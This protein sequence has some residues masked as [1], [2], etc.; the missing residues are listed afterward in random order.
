[1]KINKKF[2]QFLAAMLILIFHIWI[3][4]WGN[5][6][7]DF[8]LKTGYIGVDIFFFLSAYSLADKDIR[9]LSFIKNRF[10]TVYGKYVILV[11]IAAVIKGMRTSRIVKILFGI[12]LFERGGGAFLWFVPAILLF[13]LLYPLF[14]KWN[15]KYKGVIVLICWF[16]IGLLLDRVIGYT[17]IFI[18]LNRIPILMAGYYL[19]RK[20]LPQWFLILCIP[21]GLVLMDLWG[22]KYRLNVPFSEF[23]YVIAVALAV[24]ISAISG[25]V[26]PSKIWDNLG[27]ATLELYGLSMIF[28]TKIAAAI[29]RTITKSDFFCGQQALGAFITNVATVFILYG[30]AYILNKIFAA[31]MAFFKR[32]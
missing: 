6:V 5:T 26:K 25:F 2:L 17:D 19:K 18:F 27:S 24:G 3:P 22:Y 14:V 10:A 32:R 21:V 30:C 23:Y 9:Y 8:V 16:I 12:E 31:A 1:M 29:Y 7:E 28:G 15:S 13:Y 4:V 11:V 20:Q